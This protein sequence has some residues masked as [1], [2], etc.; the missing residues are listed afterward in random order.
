LMSVAF[1]MKN[2]LLY[3]KT[4]TTYSGW[5]QIIFNFCILLCIYEGYSE[6]NL[7]LFLATNVGAGESLCMRGSVTWL[8]A[9]Q[10]IT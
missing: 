10:T 6:S 5:E 7:R 1:L 4:V 8:T 3:L 9:L 2:F